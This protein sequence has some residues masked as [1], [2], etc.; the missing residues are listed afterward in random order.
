MQARDVEPGAIG[1]EAAELSQIGATD[2]GSVAG[3]GQHDGPHLLLLAQ[4]CEGFP[5]S[6]DEGGA[7]A[8]QLLRIGDRDG[9]DGTDV[10]VIFNLH[11]NACFVHAQ[12]PFVLKS[13]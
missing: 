7:Q 2:K 12:L 9:G 6:D 1:A 3:A 11:I 5:Q 4:G 8:I 10:G 13:V